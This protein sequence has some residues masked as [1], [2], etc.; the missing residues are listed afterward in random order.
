MKRMWA[1]LA[2][3][4]GLAAGARGAE[5]A[6]VELATSGSPASAAIFYEKTFGW[7]A[8]RLGEGDWDPVVL[9]RGDRVIG[10]VAHR[11]GERLAKARTRW[12]GF[13]AAEDAAAV[14]K[15]AEEAG[16]RLIEGEHRG[17]AAGTK[18]TRTFSVATGAAAPWKV[19][20][21]GPA[22]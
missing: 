12:L 6:G 11:Q 3:L 1:V 20:V 15:R 13:F 8:E 19:S 2:G 4:G 7:T 18:R 9:R 17:A 16:G 21:L 10:G 22:L 14:E 5:L